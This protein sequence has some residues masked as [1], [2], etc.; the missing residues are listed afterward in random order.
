MVLIP[1][2]PFRM[3]A[4]LDIESVDE[5]PVHEVELRAYCIDRFEVTNDRVAEAFNWALREGLIE[6]VNGAV[7]SRRGGRERLLD[8]QGEHTGIVWQDGRFEL[9]ARKG[10]GHPC[11]G[12][13][14]YGAAACCNVFS[15]MEDRPPC[16]APDT[17]S[18]NREAEG[19][20]LPTEA[21]WEKAAR[22][23]EANRR[24]PWSDADTISHRRANYY[25][26]PR[27]RYDVSATRRFHPA[28]GAGTHPSTSPV[29]AFPPNAYGL[30]DMAGNVW[31][32]CGD[33]H[34]L[35]YYAESPSR[36][37]AG[38]KEGSGRV[39]RGGSWLHRSECCRAA[40]RDDAS[41]GRAYSDVGFRTVRSAGADRP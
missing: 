38:P 9:G 32:W 17:W 27:L 33:W 23:G 22:G 4:V 39:K 1:A 37:P 16:Y 41:P 34:G 36:D 5:R 2:G 20:R 11:V 25:S 12:V 21:E 24:F 28:Y 13:T 8:L 10:S 31:E 29:G 35:T 30:H 19:Y 15:L 14:W 26:S 40:S 18:C 3:G 6:V 7:F